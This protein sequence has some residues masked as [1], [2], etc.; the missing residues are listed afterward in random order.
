MVGAGGTGTHLMPAMLAYLRAWHRNQGTEYQVVVADGDFFEEKNLAR[1][2]FDVGEVQANKAEAMLRMFPGHPMI[3]VARYIGAADIE[4]MV[5]DGDCV[6][7]CADN[8]S[9]RRLIA[10]HVKTLD[11]AV[12]VNGGNELNDGSVQLWV[13]ENGTNLTPPITFGHPEIKFIDEQ[14]RSAMDCMAAA[15]LPGGEQTILAN[16]TS[17]N[18]MLLALR[19]WHS[20][21]FRVE[22]H[23]RGWTELQFDLDAGLIE[24]IDMRDRRNWAR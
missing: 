5:Q 15:Q 22:G 8:H 4:Q 2:L 3:A 6:L 10:D 19:R 14:D 13:R 1:Q 9:V 16:M 11:N 21:E 18:F 7:I 12:V 20:G 23:G 17:A 24:H